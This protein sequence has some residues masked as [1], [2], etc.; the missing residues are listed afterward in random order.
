[1]GDRTKIINDPADLVPLIYTFNDDKNTEI[2]RKLTEGEITEESLKKEYGEDAEKVLE[3]LK[4]IGLV[5]SDWSMGSDGPVKEYKSSYSKFRANFE[6]NLEDIVEILRISTCEGTIENGLLDNGKEE[7][8]KK[9]C[10][11]EKTISEI[12]KET[13]IK[14][15]LVRAVAK[16]STSIFIKGNKIKVK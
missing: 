1:M 13:G 16:R 10:E 7:V 3:L 9:A 15:V 5:K 2:F 4:S 14:E 6:C 12:S 8:F 11:E